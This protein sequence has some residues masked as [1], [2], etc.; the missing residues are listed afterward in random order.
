MFCSKVGRQKFV[1]GV[2]NAAPLVC[3]DE[4]DASRERLHFYKPAA[5]RC[6]LDERV[7]DR[8]NVQVQPSWHNSKKRQHE[9]E[10]CGSSHHSHPTK[11]LSASAL[12][13]EDMDLLNLY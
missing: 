11:R 13:A 2:L 6:T 9:P 10:S 7:S 12:S 3:E 1:R 4:D 8:E 5:N